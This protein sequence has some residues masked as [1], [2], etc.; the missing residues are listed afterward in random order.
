MG[1]TEKGYN[2]VLLRMEKGEKYI[3][4]LRSMLI[5]QNNNV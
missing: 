4:L 1:A 5:Y 3:C 2:K